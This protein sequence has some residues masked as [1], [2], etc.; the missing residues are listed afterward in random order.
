MKAILLLSGLA[1]VEAQSSYYGGGLGD[2]VP[3]T[4]YR[5]I[6]IEIKLV[7][8]AMEKLWKEHHINECKKTEDRDRVE[9]ELD[10]Y[11]SEI[12]VL[13]NSDVRCGTGSGDCDPNNFASNTPAEIITKSCDDDDSVD[14]STAASIEATMSGMGRQDRLF[15]GIDNNAIATA[16]PTRPS[17]AN[18][19]AAKTNLKNYAEA[20]AKYCFEVFRIDQ[21]LQALL[22]VNENQ[23]QDAGQGGHFFLQMNSNSKKKANATAF[24]ESRKRTDPC[25]AAAGETDCNQISVEQPGGMRP[26]WTG[27]G[28]APLGHNYGGVPF[29]TWTGTECKDVCAGDPGAGSC[30]DMAGYCKDDAGACSTMMNDI[31]LELKKCM[32]AKYQTEALKAN[33]DW[34]ESDLNRAM[35]IY[36]RSLSHWTSAQKDLNLRHERLDGLCRKAKAARK[37][38]AALDPVGIED[39]DGSPGVVASYSTIISQL[40]TAQQE[41]S[42]PDFRKYFQQTA[43]PQ[44]VSNTMTFVQTGMSKEERTKAGIVRRLKDIH[45]RTGIQ[46]AQNLVSFIQKESQPTAA[47]LG[48]T[49]STVLGTIMYTINERRTMAQEKAARMEAKRIS[50]LADLEDAASLVNQRQAEYDERT[51][52]VHRNRALKEQRRQELVRATQEATAAQ[53]A[54]EEANTE[55]GNWQQETSQ[56]LLEAQDQRDQ[57]QQEN[58]AMYVVIDAS[59]DIPPTTANRI[60]TVCDRVQGTLQDRVVQLENYR[61]QED[62]RQQAIVGVLEDDRDAANFAKNQANTAWESARDALGVEA[63]VNPSAPA[64]ASRK[65]RDDAR[66]ALTSS[67]DADKN[68]KIECVDF[69]SD[70]DERIDEEQR[71]VAGLIELKG[72]L[73]HLLTTGAHSSRV[74][75][76]EGWGTI[77]AGLD[78]DQGCLQIDDKTDCE[79]FGSNS[80][81]FVNGLFCYPKLAGVDGA[82]AF[83]TTQGASPAGE[84]VR[85]S[86]ATPDQLM[87][88]FMDELEGEA[89]PHAGHAGSR[90]RVADDDTMPNNDPLDFGDGSTDKPIN[91]P[92]YR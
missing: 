19:I 39:A 37:V 69:L 24:L 91:D 34:E 51:L 42:R 92:N 30:S 79:T 90:V 11:A 20:S 76:A 6:E 58:T 10:M 26:P 83:G 74:A 41:L 12:F 1:A 59:S 32:D 29:C 40:S 5:A 22:K 50:C 66:S 65:D 54:Y 38:R 45:Q 28:D 31:D 53:V 81:E 43:S 44:S 75:A 60:K 27:G 17:N 86:G 72:V 8:E 18:F 46:L 2:K 70:V 78:A 71:Q 55:W 63:K 48:T 23:I 36:E 88:D 33:M 73:S 82:G 9:L 68:K 47:L 25:A 13:M 14:L 62:Q 49:G 67:K 61:T 84:V 56:E 89:L 35:E 15:D 7:N 80:C 52:V 16:E 87:S 21:N 85:T 57:M 3:D 4:C 64:T 77:E